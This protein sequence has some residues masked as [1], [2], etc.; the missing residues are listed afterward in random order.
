[1]AADDLPAAA[2]A[3]DRLET[4]R[5]LRG[6]LALQIEATDS[7]RDVAALSQRLM[8]VL[9]QIDACE[10]ADPVREGTAL[11]EVNA[12]RAAKTSKGPGRA[13]RG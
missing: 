9:A 10:K 12:R 4:L 13:A 8:D 3:G 11:D 5:A 6:V 7:A 1:M 2:R